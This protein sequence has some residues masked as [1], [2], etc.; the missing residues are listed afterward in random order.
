MHCEIEFKNN[1]WLTLWVRRDGEG[2]S[3]TSAVMLSFWKSVNLRSHSCKMRVIEQYSTLTPSLS[4]GG[5]DESRWNEHLLYPCSRVRLVYLGYQGLPLIKHLLYPCSNT[6]LTDAS[7]ISHVPA[8]T[9]S[10]IFFKEPNPKEDGS[11]VAR[12]SVLMGSR[13][14]QINCFLNLLILN[15][16]EAETEGEFCSVRLCVHVCMYMWLNGNK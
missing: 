9:S 7:W 1:W 15:D 5:Q 2:T 11:T 10:S 12:S 6:V 3:M 8:V 13:L 14:G 4:T 16:K